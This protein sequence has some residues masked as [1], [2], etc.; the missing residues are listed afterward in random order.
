MQLS[1]DHPLTELLI[2]GYENNTVWVNHLPYHHSIIVTPKSVLPWDEHLKT[3]FEHDAE[4]VLIGSSLNLFTTEQLL[5]FYEKNIGVEMMNL[6]A[7]CRTYNLL[8]NEGRKVIAG[9][10]IRFDT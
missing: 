8:A 10:I 6:Q 1:E 7:A 5:D 3:L 2:T 9:L 4:L